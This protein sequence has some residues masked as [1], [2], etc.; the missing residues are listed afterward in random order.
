MKRSSLLLLLGCAGLLACDIGSKSVTGTATAS[1]DPST[2]TGDDPLDTE[3]STGPAPG[4]ASAT[5]TTG[6]DPV[7]TAGGRT[8]VETITVLESLDA[9][10]STGLRPRDVLEA[11]E[12]TFSGS[13]TWA[14]EGPARY[15][16]ALGPAPLT[17]EVTYAGGEIRDVDAELVMACEHDGPCPCEDR[18]EVDMDMRVRSEDGVLNEAWTVAVRHQPTSDGF[19]GNGTSIYHRFDPDQTQGSLSRASFTLSGDVVIEE[20]VATGE[21]RGGSLAGGF[22]LQVALGGAGGGIGFGP[23]ATFGTVTSLDACPELGSAS[24]SAAGCTLV[25]GVPLYGTPPASCEC[26]T[27]AEYCFS[28]PPDGESS[29]SLYTRTIPDSYGA[30]DEVV[31][32]EMPVA[33]GQGSWRP[34]SDAPEVDL[35]GCFGDAAVCP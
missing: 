28:G 14:A 34:C 6:E 23:G 1:D 17:I 26:A 27:I 10:G 19:G 31:L 32:F 30:Y 5:T 20:M 9:I 24:C 13:M 33:P 4:T 11:S 21:F 7:E 35:C 2:S 3:S 15:D 8:C 18:L 25:S 22:N 16:G 12:G 29:P